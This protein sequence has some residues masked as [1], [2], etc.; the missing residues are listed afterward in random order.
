MHKSPCQYVSFSET[1]PVIATYGPTLD[2][3]SL[4]MIEE[5]P[6]SNDFMRLIPGRLGGIEESAKLLNDCSLFGL[7]TTRGLLVFSAE[8]VF[9]I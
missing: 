5:L 9:V 4:V 7:T 8:A 2:S 6:F 1:E 3:Y